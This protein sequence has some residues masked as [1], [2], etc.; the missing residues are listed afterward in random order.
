MGITSVYLDA[1][2]LTVAVWH[3]TVS[4]AE[5]KHFVHVQ[6]ANDPDW[7]R[8]K[9]HLADLTTFDPGELSSEDLDAV[10]GLVSGRIVKIAR[11]REAIVASLGWEL[12][13]GFERR[14]QRLG[15]MTVVFNSVPDACTWLGADLERVREIVSGLRDE[16]RANASG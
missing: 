11:R 16:L 2:D 10:V 12:A 13:R 4:G 3:G 14:I 5:W 1:E 8:G 15:A 9:R 7:P 6:L